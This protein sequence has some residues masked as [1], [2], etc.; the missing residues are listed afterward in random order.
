M[1]INPSMM[2]LYS[3]S[4]VSTSVPKYY[5]LNLLLIAAPLI[6]EGHIVKMLDLQGETSINNLV[7]KVVI[8]FKP[9]FAG[10]TFTTPLCTQA[11][12]ISKVING[13]DQK[14]KIVAGGVHATL[15]P[16]E[17]L[18]QS[19]IDIV[20]IG[21]GDFTFADIVNESNLSDVP[22][23]AFKK[24]EGIEVTRPR[25]LVKEL[26]KIPFPEMKLVNLKDYWVPTTYTRRNPVA[27]IETSRG[28]PYGC[29]YCNKSLFGNTFRGKSPKR[30]VGEFLRLEKLGFKEIH[31]ADDGF[32]TDMKRAEEICKLLIKRKSRILIN[33]TNGIRADRVSLK[34]LKLMKKAGFYRVS[35][36]VESGSDEVL[37]RIKKGLKKADILRAFKIC[38]KV[39]IETTGFFMLGLPGETKADVMETIK[40]AIKLNPDIAKFSIVM[41]IPGTPLFDEL[42]SN[43]QIL[44]KNWSDYGFYRNVPTFQHEN[45]SWEELKNLEALAYKRFYLRIGWFF[46]GFRMAHL[47]SISFSLLRNLLRKL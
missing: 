19:K 23:I 5:P 10:I 35:F 20:V 24:G 32:T 2:E 4:I 42:E 3:K 45:L 31:I 9:D 26:D 44:T 14:I 43:G 7:R 30:V 8:S 21:E 29:T 25:Q 17:V 39:G 34:L 18:E 22:G 33:C 41:P 11:F 15:A 37:D 13:I 28:C 38:K 6:K 12:K 16:K 46:K 47:R 36:G 1:L 40:F 27:T